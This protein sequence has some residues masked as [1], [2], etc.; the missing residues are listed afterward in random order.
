MPQLPD[1]IMIQVPQIFK[2]LEIAR[3]AGAAGVVVMLYDWILTL[4]REIAH[5]WTTD[6]WT[7]PSVLFVVVGP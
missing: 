3:Y 5:I 6:R 1:Y 2:S 7:V 4:P